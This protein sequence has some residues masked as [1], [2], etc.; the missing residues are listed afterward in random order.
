MKRC[1]LFFV[2]LTAVLIAGAQYSGDIKIER[3]LKTDTTGAGQPIDY[4]NIANEEVSILKVTIPPGKSTGWHKHLFP[5]FAYVLQG[6]VT[7]QQEHGKKVRFSKNES[8]AESV[9]M[10][11]IGTNEGKKPVVLIVFYMGEKDK[12]ISVKK[13]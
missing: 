8:I 1:F 13:E 3:L 12:P 6:T 11:H 10:Y 4:P 2:A 9:N 7:V 5:V